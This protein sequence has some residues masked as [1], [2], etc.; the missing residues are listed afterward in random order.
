MRLTIGNAV[1]PPSS[2]SDRYMST[3]ATRGDCSSSES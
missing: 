3:V 1:S 2:T